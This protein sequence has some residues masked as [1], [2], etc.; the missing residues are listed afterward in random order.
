M[1]FSVP[2]V[3]TSWILMMLYAR[4][5]EGKFEKFIL[6]QYICEF[7]CVSRSW[8]EA[9]LSVAGVKIKTAF[10]L[11]CKTSRNTLTRAYKHH[12]N[13]TWWKIEETIKCAHCFISFVGLLDVS[14]AGNRCETKHYLGL[15]WRHLI[16]DVT[17]SV[18]EDFESPCSCCGR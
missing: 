13:S 2:F 15:S 4:T 3:F 9:I 10:F 7:F 1:W 14:L 5:V 12:L 8:V 18:F 11:Q 16:Y 17:M 6:L